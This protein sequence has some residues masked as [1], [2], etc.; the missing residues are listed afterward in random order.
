M[1]IGL[2]GKANAMLVRTVTRVVRDSAIAAI[3]KGS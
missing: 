2:R 3:A 1:I